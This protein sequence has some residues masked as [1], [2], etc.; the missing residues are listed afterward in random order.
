MTAPHTQLNIQR[1]AYVW[2]I[3]V[4]SIYNTHMINGVMIKRL[5]RTLVSKTLR[6]SHTIEASAMY[7]IA[8]KESR[9][10]HRL[11]KI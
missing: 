4:Q 11:D 1:R 8:F 5:L 2:W 3:V 6:G 7:Y 9:G 10:F